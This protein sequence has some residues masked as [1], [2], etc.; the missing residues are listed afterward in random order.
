MNESIMS[1]KNASTISLKVSKKDFEQ[2]NPWRHH[3]EFWKKNSEFLCYM[4]VVV[5]EV[6]AHGYRRS[7]ERV[8]C[9]S[10]NQVVLNSRSRT[11]EK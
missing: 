8:F 7:L 1:E 6:V 4:L 9:E 11:I 3:D 2:Q 5:G 10:A